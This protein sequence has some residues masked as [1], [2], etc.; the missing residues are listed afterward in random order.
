MDARTLH[1]MLPIAIVIGLGFSLYSA[2]ESVTPAAQGSCTVNGFFSCQKV[3][4]SAFT[5]TFGIQDYWFGIIGFAAMLA[6]DVP[7]MRT[8]RRPWLLALAGLST[9][10]LLVSVYLA[11][12]ELVQIQALCLICTGAYL[13]NVVVWVIAIALVRQQRVAGD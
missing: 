11:Y 1:A 5:T 6:V 7:L 12:V 13:S 4:Q 2:Y 10:G 8:Y 9:L 3:D